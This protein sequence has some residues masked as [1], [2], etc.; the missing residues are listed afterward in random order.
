[1]NKIDSKKL[2]ELRKAAGLSQAEL[3]KIL[4]ISPKNIS[5]YETGRAKPPG[6]TLLAYMIQLNAR[7]EEI[8]QKV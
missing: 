5:H 2:K 7:P 6:D 4:G 1:M 8:L 3:A